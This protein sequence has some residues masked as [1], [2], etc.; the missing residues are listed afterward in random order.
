MRQYPRGTVVEKIEFAFSLS[1]GAKG[2]IST[3]KV[4]QFPVKLAFATTSHKIQGQTVKKPRKVVVD[5]RSTPHSN[6]PPQS[7]P[8]HPTQLIYLTHPNRPNLNQPTQPNPTHLN[9]PTQPNLPT[10]P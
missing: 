6:H 8:T 3:A 7:N 2:N 1:K 5:I 4:I 10:N 9:Q